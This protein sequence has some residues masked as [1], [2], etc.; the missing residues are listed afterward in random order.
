MT[1]LKK[2]EYVPKEGRGTGL[3]KYIRIDLEGTGYVFNASEIQ[4]LRMNPSNPD[5]KQQITEVY[6]IITYHSDESADVEPIQVDR[7]MSRDL[8]ELIFSLDIPSTTP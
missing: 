1:E 5:Y 3:E 7:N 8:G 2:L 4:D 6:K